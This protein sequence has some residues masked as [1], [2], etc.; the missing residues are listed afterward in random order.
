L[1]GLAT[2]AEQLREVGITEAQ[3]RTHL[4]AILGRR[5]PLCP[6]ES[7]RERVEQIAAGQYVSISLPWP[8]LTRLALP[9]LPG[10]LTILGGGVGSS[11]SFMLLQAMLSWLEAGVDAAA[12]ALEGDVTFH[13]HRAL[14]QLA[15]VSAV[16]EPEWV[17]AHA[18]QMRELL[19]RHERTL[20]RLA[21]HW[22]IARSQNIDTQDHTS[23]WV[24]QQARAGRRIICIDPVTALIRIGRPWEADSRFIKTLKKIAETYGVTILLVTHPAKGVTDP[25]REN[26][27]GGA[28]YERFCDTLLVLQAHDPRKSKALTPCGTTEIEHNRTLRIEKA[29]HGSGTGLR[30]AMRFSGETLLMAEQGII[31][32]TKRKGQDP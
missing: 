31:T 5:L 9:L 14:A 1:G 20:A 21:D 24:E 12:L 26:L 16:T 6:V 19:D 2:A 13:L 4:E 10:S 25:T 23:A 27:S 29:R 8:Q 32:K 7:L 30:L 11:K 3:L 17:A 28:A 18:D 15:G 22:V